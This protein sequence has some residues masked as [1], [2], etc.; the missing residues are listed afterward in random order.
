MSYTI[1]DNASCKPKSPADFVIDGYTAYITFTDGTQKQ[2][3]IP[4][5]DF[6]GDISGKADIIHTHTLSEIS[7]W[8]PSAFATSEQGGKADSAIQHQDMVDYISSQSFLTND[9]LQGTND[10]ISNHIANTS[11]PHG[12]TKGQVGLGSVDNTADIDKIVSTPQRQA[13]DSK[14]NAA[15]SYI[16]SKLS[17]KVDV[18]AGSRLMTNLEGDKLAKFD[19]KHYK[20]PVAD[21]TALA[22]LTEA[23]LFDRE[24]R[25]V[26][27]EGKDYFYDIDAIS[28]D[29]APTDQSGGTGFWKTVN[30]SPGSTYSQWLLKTGGTFRK[31]MVDGAELDLRAS[32]LLSVVY[33]PEG[34][35]TYSTTATQN[36]TD[37]NLRDRSTHTGT[38]AIETIEN[39]EQRLTRIVIPLDTV[40]EYNALRDAGNDIP[41]A[42]YVIKC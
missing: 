29:Q 26:A 22:S 1:N 32:G 37:A 8:D 20:A 17:L 28:G 21:L 14:Y 35:V 2:Q 5:V 12:V 11:N 40:E 36:D 18:V 33:T 34:V 24:R 10:N 39:L 7:D 27:S 15:I 23:S 3:E 31:N 19:D 13:I 41:G 6:T 4:F 30:T 25:F 38:Q 9:S 42:M 16:N